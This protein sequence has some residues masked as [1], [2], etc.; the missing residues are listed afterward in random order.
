MKKLFISILIS[1]VIIS[2]NAAGV[3]TDVREKILFNDGWLFARSDDPS[4][5]DIDF[6]DSAWRPLQLPHDWSIEGEY[7]PDFP[8]GRFNGYFPEG[9]GW[10]RKSFNIPK[11]DQHKQFVVEFEG[12]FMNSQVWINGRYLGNR[13]FGYATFRYDLTEY[14]NFGGENTIAVRVDNTIPGADRWYHGSGIYRDVYLL[15]TNYV[16]FRHNG[17]VSITTPVAESCRAVVE[18]DYDILG[19]FFTP[20]E[21]SLFKR[22]RWNRSQTKWHNEPRDHECIVRSVVI[23]SEGNEIARTE[24]KHNIRNYDINYEVRQQVEFKNPARW[25]AETPNLY[26]LRSEIEWDGKILDD[27]VTRF[28]VRNIEYRPHQGLY[29]NE[30][31]V[32]LWGVCL[33]QDAGSLGS[34]VPKKVW[35]YRLGKLKEMGCNAIR[36]A[37]TPFAPEFYD[38][39]DSMGFYVQNES[40]DEWTCSWN[41]NWTENNRGKSDN[42]Y[43]HLFEQ[44]A[45]T[46]LRD[47]IK[48]DRNHPSVIMWTVGNEIPD[49]RYYPDAG[50]TAKKLYDICK[51]EDPTRPVTLGDNSSQ[52]TNVNGIQD[53]LD[54]LGFNYIE[55]DFGDNMYQEIY[56][57]RPE[58][59]CY[60]SEVNKEIEYQLAVRDN[61]YVIGSFVWTG[62]DY[63]GETKDKNLRGWNTSPF[64]MTLNMKADGAM[65]SACWNSE[66]RIYITT[67][68]VS[69]SSPEQVE[70][71]TEAGE[72]IIMSRERLFTWNK[73][74]GA[75]VFVTVYSN[76]DEVEL[77]VNGRSLGRKTNDWSKYFVEYATE[78]KSG[79]VEAIGYRKGKKVTSTALESTTEAKKI[80]ATPVWGELKRDSRDIAIIEVDIT[81]A[82]GR[83]VPEAMNIVNVNVEGGARLL[84]VDSPNLYYNGNFKSKS[85]EAMNGNLLVTVQSNGED[86][87]TKITLTSEGL[88]TAVVEL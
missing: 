78:F 21:I 63:L 54:L 15:K 68:D 88:S 13:P 82:K 83:T 26:Y 36:T 35:E 71:A 64:D 87:P 48:R 39:C 19:T 49:N 86:L 55:R 20:E 16:H 9:L 62:I 50:K 27:V 69:A 51:Q 84:G 67:S 61:D 28:G 37:H 81:D 32:K 14:L 43:F 58:K 57:L 45:E 22:N 7:T 52:T 34:V 79:K 38:L 6:Y 12:V 4:Q 77:K 5:R 70:T 10:Y 60:G 47:L 42:G 3:T 66:P 17:G 73:R 25:S 30:Q 76:C 18:V 23:D 56:K 44:W 40:F 75:E 80:V 11:E 59:L 65:F 2:A 74:D 53:L 46:D 33:H 72:R 31:M 1:T 8:S 41:I 85:R 29:V 24:S